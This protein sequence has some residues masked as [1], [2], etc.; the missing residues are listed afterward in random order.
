MRRQL[1]LI[2]V[3]FVGVAALLVL[4]TGAT[5]SPSKAQASKDVYFEF[6][7]PS[8]NIFCYYSATTSPRSK[9]I[10]C[11]IMSNLKPRPPSSG[12]TDGLR[13]KAAQVHPTGRASFPCVG[14]VVLNKSAYRLRYGKTLRRGGIACKSRKAGLRC[15]NKSRHGFFLSREHS[16]LF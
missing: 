4:G 10:R 5:A 11:D 14:D 7:M 6:R 12:C 8:N 9:T 1:A 16:Y 13:L 2:A 3:F 15:T